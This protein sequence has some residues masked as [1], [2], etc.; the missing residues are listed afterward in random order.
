M[1]IA[2]V[3]RGTRFR[4]VPDAVCCEFDDGLAILNLQSNIYFSLNEVG[5][6]VWGVIQTPRRLSEICEEVGA[7]F[8]VDAGRCAADVDALVESMTSH[9]LVVRHVEE[10]S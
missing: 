1:T 3:D 7:E 5:A 10:A 2:G 4:A 9:G 8:D 6:F